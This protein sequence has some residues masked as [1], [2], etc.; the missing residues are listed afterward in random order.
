MTAARRKGSRFER[1]VATYLAEHGFPGAE[2]RVMGGSKDRGDIAGVTGWALE[3]KATRDVDL[4]G[5]TTEAKAE[6]RNAGVVDY[7]AILKRR[8]HP[9]AGAYVVLPLD[10]FVHL[11]NRERRVT[12]IVAAGDSA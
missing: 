8:N 2:R 12:T 3:C 4:A 9:V 11:L 5:A 10:R 6:A 7:A 1:D